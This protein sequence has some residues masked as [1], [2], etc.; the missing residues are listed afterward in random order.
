[1]EENK[2]AKIIRIIGLVSIIGG[3]ISSLILGGIFKMQV[4]TYYTH[5]EY[6]W[7]IAII[8]SIISLVD[9]II[10]MGFSEIINLLQL[11]YNRQFEIINTLNN[12]K[13]KDNEKPSKIDNEKTSITDSNTGVGSYTGT[14][15][16]TPH[17]WR[18][19]KCNKMISELPCPYCGDN[20]N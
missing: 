19:A 6:N 14:E 1:M 20:F 8:G 9:G 5:E 15:N 4:G 16:N 12:L 11:N 7:Y 2:I 3:I 18:C 17:T 10:F 13:K